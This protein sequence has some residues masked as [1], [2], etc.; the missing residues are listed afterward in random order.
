MP[1][2]SVTSLAPYVAKYLCVCVRVRRG[3][4]GVLIPPLWVGPFAAFFLFS[5]FPHLSSPSGPA[6]RSS[7]EPKFSWRANWLYSSPQKSHVSHWCW[8]ATLLIDPPPPPLLARTCT[9]THT[10]TYTHAR[11][12]WFFFPFFFLSDSIPPKLVLTAQSGLWEQHVH[13]F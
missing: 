9:H 11:T 12:Q 2:Q 4:R 10:H 3:G 13:S 5:L 1:C 7:S 8:R 6:R